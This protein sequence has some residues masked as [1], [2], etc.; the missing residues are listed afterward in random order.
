MG[1]ENDMKKATATFFTAIFSTFAAVAQ[2]VP[3]AAAAANRRLPVPPEV[4]ANTTESMNN[5]PISY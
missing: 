3:D 1:K 2:V 5:P 4:A